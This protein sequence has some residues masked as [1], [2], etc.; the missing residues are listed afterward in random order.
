MRQL[1]YLV[2]ALGLAVVVGCGSGSGDVDGGSN[3]FDGSAGID[4]SDEVCVALGDPCVGDGEC[5]EN[6]CEGAVCVPEDCL[7]QGFACEEGSDCCSMTCNED[8]L[9]EATVIPGDCETFGGSCS[10]DSDCCSDNCVNAIGDAC[11]GGVGC[12]CGP[13]MGCY[14]SGDPCSSDGACCNSLCDDPDPGVEEAVCTA[15]GS[16]KTAGEPCGTAGYNGSCCSTIC[17]DSHGE[18]INRCQHLG[19]CRIQDDLCTNDAECCSGVCSQKGQT[20]DGRPIM[21]C[22]NAG[23]CAPVGEVCGGGG[24]TSNCCPSGGGRRGCEDT[25]AGFSRCFGGGDKDCVLAGQPCDSID[26]CCTTPPGLVCDEGPQQIDICCLPDGE[27]C[28]FGSLC[29]SGVCGPSTDPNDPDGTLRCSPECIPNGGACVSNAECCG[30]CDNG[31]C[32]SQC[33]ECTGPQLG[34]F[35]TPGTPDPCC[36]YPDVTCQGTEFAQCALAP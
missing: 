16:C 18:G 12:T 22:A 34:D 3:G 29:C 14:A 13:S 20:K 17:L 15:I 1:L 27:I 19:G 35:C 31:T 23:N 30:C 5:C 6:R 36:G 25:G 26:E 4:A 33:G 32:A 2:G 11:G 7:S 28:S 9:C 21:R 8:S 10:M 24:A